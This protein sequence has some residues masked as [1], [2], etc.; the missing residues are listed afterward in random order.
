VVEER[1]NG[2]DGSNTGTEGGKWDVPRFSVGY[3]E[4]D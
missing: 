4:S 3:G 2:G 1:A